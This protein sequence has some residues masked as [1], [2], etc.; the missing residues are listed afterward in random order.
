MKKKILNID[1]IVLSAIQLNE[2]KGGTAVNIQ[3]TSGQPGSTPSI[4]IR[5]TSS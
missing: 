5:G 4:R 1:S 2:I 3:N